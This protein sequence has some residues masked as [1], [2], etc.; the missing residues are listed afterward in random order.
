MLNFIQPFGEICITGKDY[1]ILHSEISRNYLPNV[2][3]YGG[4]KGSLP[5]LKNRLSPTENQI[6]ICHSQTCFAPV[7]NARAALEI[8]NNLNN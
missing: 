1:K 5:I 6:F 8:L 7:S 3:F 2:L 4:E